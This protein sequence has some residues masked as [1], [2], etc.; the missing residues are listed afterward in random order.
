[1]SSASWPQDGDEGGAPPPRDDEQ[2]PARRRPPSRWAKAF[3]GL[4]VVVFLLTML[5][6]LWTESLWFDSIGFSGM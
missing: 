4:A 5:A 3:L 2:P 1:M 6:G